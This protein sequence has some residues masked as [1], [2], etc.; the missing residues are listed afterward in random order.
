MI[1]PLV[2]LVLRLSDIR[3]LRY[4]GASVAALAIDIS[5]FFA[6]L[7]LGLTAGPAS[8]LAYSLG[9]AAH[10]VISSQLV[11]H[12]CLAADGPGRRLQKVFFVSSALA[13]LAVTTLTVTLADF[14][15]INPP[16]AKFAAI[17]AS[18][19][20]T[21]VLRAQIVFKPDGRS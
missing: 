7:I 21:Y 2:A 10:W 17:I 16:L 1:R 14:A 13:G 3:S 4:F 8:A 5:T 20:L 19:T 11:F 12:N 15:G 9:I 18:F 6:A